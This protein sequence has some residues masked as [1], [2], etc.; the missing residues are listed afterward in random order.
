MNGN[1]ACKEDFRV[2]HIGGRVVAMSPRPTFN[3]NRIALNI[4]VLFENY[5]KGKRC[6]AISDGTDLFLSEENNFIPDMMVVCDP[7]KIRPNGVY[8]APDL[9][10]EVLSPSTA[11]YDRGPKK[12]AY[13]RCGVR[14]YWIV[15]PANRWVEQYLLRE[16]ALELAA[17]YVIFPDYTLEK[18]TQEEREAV[19]THFRCSL[20]DDFE[21]ALEDIFRGML[22]ETR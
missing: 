6:T 18:M 10:V 21:I 17:V 15:D 22:P 1:L 20:F 8:G 2:E 11:K 13:E 12:D 16:G 5:L 9:V 7:D 4:V 3:H 19:V 14:E